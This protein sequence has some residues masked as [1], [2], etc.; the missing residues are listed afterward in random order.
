[1]KTEVILLIKIMYKFHFKKKKILLLKNL[2]FT[3]I[4]S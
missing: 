4:A 3:I 2:I 1:M